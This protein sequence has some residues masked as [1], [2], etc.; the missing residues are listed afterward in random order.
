MD[1]ITYGKWFMPKIFSTFFSIFIFNNNQQNIFLLTISF[2]LYQDQKIWNTILGNCFMSKET[3]SKSLYLQT[4]KKQEKK[5]ENLEFML[6][7]YTHHFRF[8]LLQMLCHINIGSLVLH[9]LSS[10]FISRQ[11]GNP[12]D[13]F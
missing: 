11:L 3:E 8:Q 9:F 12:L 13:L 6:E 5:Y 4:N 1:P 10:L 2:Q 7:K